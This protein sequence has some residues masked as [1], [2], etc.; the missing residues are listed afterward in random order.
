MI[1]KSLWKYTSPEGKLEALSSYLLSLPPMILAD[2]SLPTAWPP[3]FS[4]EPPH[5]PQVIPKNQ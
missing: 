5:D 1:T 4:Q 3:T 2:F